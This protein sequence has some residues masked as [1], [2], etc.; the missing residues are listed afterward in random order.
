MTRTTNGTG[1]ATIFWSLLIHLPANF[2]FLWLKIHPWIH[3]IHTSFEE[4]D[5]VNRALGE[6]AFPLL[7]ASAAPATRDARLK[8]LG[9]IKRSKDFVR[10]STAYLTGI[11]WTATFV[12]GGADRASS[13]KYAAHQQQQQATTAAGLKFLEMIFHSVRKYNNILNI[14]I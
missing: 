2:D 14:Q 1:S 10:H 5:V 4:E 3:K 8:R 7:P 13:Q 11:H 9:Q 6:R 12:A